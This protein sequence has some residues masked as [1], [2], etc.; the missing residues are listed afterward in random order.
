M[1]KTKDT[2]TE[3]APRS[4]TSALMATADGYASTD[5]RGKEGITGDDLRL[6]FLAIAQKTSKALDPSEGTYLEGL[7]FLDLYNT[8]TREI[9]GSTPLY[10]LPLLHRKRAHL[11]S[12]DN[13]LEREPRDWNDPR[14]TWQGARELG[15]TKPEGVRIYDWVVLLL[16]S[17]E[18]VVISFMSKSF[19]AGQS[20]ATFVKTRPGP[21]FAGRYQIRAIL[22]KNELGNFGKFLVIPAGKPDAREAEFAATAYDSI[23]GRTFIVEEQEVADDPPATERAIDAVHEAVPF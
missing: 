13:K 4:S 14:V 1:A 19:G 17:F 9:Y 8:E 21:A 18:M 5:T 11:R 10:F 7:K 22:D 6:P 3:L 23:K 2:K 16:P 15:L 20:L 12:A